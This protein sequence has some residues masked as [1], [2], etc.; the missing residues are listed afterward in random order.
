MLWWGGSMA[1]D[2]KAI[3]KDIEFCKHSITLTEASRLRGFH[4]ST[5]V[6]TFLTSN[7]ARNVV[8]LLGQSFFDDHELKNLVNILETILEEGSI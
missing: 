3:L 1:I 6:N 5:M 2:N 7:E 8:Q 4:S